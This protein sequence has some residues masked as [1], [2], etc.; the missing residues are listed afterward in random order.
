L[1]TI[2]KKLA[3]NPY[4]NLWGGTTLTW[5]ELRPGREVAKLR[6]NAALVGGFESPGSSLHP[7]LTSYTP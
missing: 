6:K 2:A 3:I 7:E 5:L 4:V 1:F